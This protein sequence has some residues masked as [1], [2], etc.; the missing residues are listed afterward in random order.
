MPRGLVTLMV[1]AFS[2]LI[3][4]FAVVLAYLVIGGISGNFP[5]SIA[6][7]GGW[8]LSII[9]AFLSTTVAFYQCES[10]YKGWRFNRYW[11]PAWGTAAITAAS[12]ALWV[13]AVYLWHGSVTVLLILSGVVSAVE[14]LTAEQGRAVGLLSLSAAS[15][16]ALAV[17]FF[18]VGWLVSIAAFMASLF[19]SAAS[20]SW[21]VW[22][23][24]VV[25]A[26]I[27]SF[28]TQWVV[29]NMKDRG[30]SRLMMAAPPA[31]RSPLAGAL[32]I[33]DYVDK[34]MELERAWRSFGLFAAAVLAVAVPLVVVHFA[35]WSNVISGGGALLGVVLAVVSLV[36]SLACY[37]WIWL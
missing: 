34:R 13:L 37:L 23:G 4:A 16:F 6:G 3:V 1:T 20:I 25:A 28:L 36:V 17:Y 33:H 8:V 27:L 2:L 11:G 30:S 35:G 5:A 21:K 12:A 26:A 22:L 19:L 10:A 29:E 15:W 18:G 24:S 32:I 31:R 9:L 14:G 7:R